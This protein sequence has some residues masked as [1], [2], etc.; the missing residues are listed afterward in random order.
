MN[1]RYVNQI[2]RLEA[3]KPGLR[4]FKKQQ[5]P[6]QA[7]N[8]CKR[9]DWMIYML[10]QVAYQVAY[11]YNDYN[12]LGNINRLFHQIANGDYAILAYQNRKIKRKLADRIRQDFPR[13]PLYIRRKP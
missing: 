9:P 8:D 6:A 3:C 7:W 2:I 4:W 11:R 1:E 12:L 13:C 5:S 10:K